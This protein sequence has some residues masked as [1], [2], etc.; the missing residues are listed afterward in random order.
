MKTIKKVFKWYMKQSS[1][2][3]AW[4]PSGMLPYL[5]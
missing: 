3:Y 5:D 4:L 1:Q 2:N